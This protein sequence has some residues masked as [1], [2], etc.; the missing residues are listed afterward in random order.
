V[1][2]FECRL[3]MEVQVQAVRAHALLPY[4]SGAAIFDRAG[5]ACCQY[6]ST[7]PVLSVICYLVVPS[8]RRSTIGDRA[9]AV[10]GPLVWS[11]PSDI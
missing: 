2:T 10:A 5:S 1:L 4:W 11:L 3:S 6:C 8:T 7:L 9:F